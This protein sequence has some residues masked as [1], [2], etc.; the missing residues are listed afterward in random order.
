MQKTSHPSSQRLNWCPK[1]VNVAMSCDTRRP[2]NVANRFSAIKE[3]F[4]PLNI[5][6][7]KV[8]TPHLGDLNAN[9]NNDMWW[10]DATTNFRSPIHPHTRPFAIQHF[11]SRT[12]SVH[13][14]VDHGIVSLEFAQQMDRQLRGFLTT[15]YPTMETFSLDPR[16][17]YRGEEQDVH[18]TIRDVQRLFATEYETRV[19]VGPTRMEDLV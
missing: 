9:S 15:R 7:A 14:S 12:P 13:F 8:G 6:I 4:G 3:A 18:M 17:I 10:A 5:M 16:S 11:L 1:I 19:A 2:F